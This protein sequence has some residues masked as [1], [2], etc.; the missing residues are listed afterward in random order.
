MYKNSLDIMIGIKYIWLN[1]IKS[2]SGRVHRQLMMHFPSLL[3]LQIWKQ[4][5]WEF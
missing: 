4:N 2:V 5:E 3:K 1:Q